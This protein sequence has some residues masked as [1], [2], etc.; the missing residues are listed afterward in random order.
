VSKS[1]IEPEKTNVDDRK[2]K[3]REATTTDETE[4]RSESRVR[5]VGSLNALFFLLI[6]VISQILPMVRKR[7]GTSTLGER[8]T[9]ESVFIIAFIAAP[10]V[11]IV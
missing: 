9:T 6:E 3:E 2:R 4:S 8:S 7:G 10:P 5:P 11:D 1:E